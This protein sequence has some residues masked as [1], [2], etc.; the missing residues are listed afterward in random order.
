[1]PTNNGKCPPFP[2]VDLK[3][4]NGWVLRNVDPTKWRWRPWPDGP[5]G[6]DIEIWQHPKK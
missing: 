6:G 3:L 1:M 4:R 2:L 5:S